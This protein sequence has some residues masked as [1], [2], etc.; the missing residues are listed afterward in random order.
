MLARIALYRSKRLLP[1]RIP[2]ESGGPDEKKHSQPR[3]REVHQ[4]VEA[5]C[6]PPEREMLVRFVPDH[7]VRRIDG[8]VE[9]GP[10]QPPDHHPEYGCNHPVREIL[11][12]TFYGRARNGALVQRIRIAAHDFRDLPAPGLETMRLER[13]GNGLHVHIETALSKKR[14]RQHRGYE[15][16]QKPRQQ[17]RGSSQEHGD[18]ERHE[19]NHAQCQ[20]AIEPSALEREACQVPGPLAVCYQH[21]D[22]F[23]GVPDPA[24]NR[25]GISGDSLNEK[26]EKRERSEHGHELRERR[27]PGC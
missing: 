4:I 16:R 18:R 13:L 26:R 10:R 17:I 23:D 9:S 7:A 20:H 15:E 14:A 2:D 27:E 11:G 3:S 8:L 1:R 22:P 6:G 25:V 19:Q 24:H 12:E 5:G 21:P